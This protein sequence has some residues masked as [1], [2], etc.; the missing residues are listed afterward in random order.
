MRSVK[1]VES[2]E[3]VNNTAINIAGSSASGIGKRV[4]FKLKGTISPP[5]EHALTDAVQSVS[6]SP[7][8][9]TSKIR[10]DE[11]SDSEER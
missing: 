6:T 8:T 10:R 4:P 2:V 5:E 7:V 11:S 9:N 1:S 3:S